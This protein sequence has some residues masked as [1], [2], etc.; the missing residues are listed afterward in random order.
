MKLY[1]ISHDL[2][3]THYSCHN[4]KKNITIKERDEAF[5]A[6]IKLAKEE[7]ELKTLE[8]SKEDRIWKI[9]SAIFVGDSRIGAKRRQI[10]QTEREEII[11]KIQDALE[12][13]LHISFENFGEFLN[14]E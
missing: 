14:T 9:E 11:D 1:P 2:P 3:P 6:C 13:A 7:F 8:Y 4:C 10:G 12:D 5:E